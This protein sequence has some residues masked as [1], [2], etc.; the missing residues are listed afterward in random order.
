[1]AQP[2]SEVSSARFDA[3]HVAEVV[4]CVTR[5]RQYQHNPKHSS[6]P[7]GHQQQHCRR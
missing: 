7:C 4:F 6:A 2:A 3:S 1:V 5:V